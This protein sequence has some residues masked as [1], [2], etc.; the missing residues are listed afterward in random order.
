MMGERTLSLSLL[1]AFVLLP[2]LLPSW[3]LTDF[4][5]YFAYAIFAASLAFIWGHVGLL[6]LG[7]AVYFGLGAYAMSVVTLG[8]TPLPAWSIAGLVAAILTAGAAAYL[9]G[10]FF[11]GGKNLRGAFF[12]IVTLALAFIFERIAINSTWLGGMNGLMSV[13]PIQVFGHDIYDPLPLYFTMLAALAAVIILLHF[14]MRSRFGLLLAGVRENELRAATLGHHTRR[15]KVLAFTLSGM[16]AGFAGALFVAQF[17]FA[18]PSLI[19]FSLSADVLIW[20]A[21]GGRGNI[22]AAAL[23][24]IAVRYLESQ[25]SGSLGTYWPLAAGLFFM[26]SVLLLPRGLFGEIIAR[27]TRAPA[28]S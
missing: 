13:P 20:V 10:S 6:S 8:M 15:L 24:A 25:L 2:L 17:G 27:L 16:V 11:F 21:L 12:G 14:V 22:L 5:I 4:A 18:S 23:G 19:G 3:A 28:Q 9:L 1:A 7:H 26:L